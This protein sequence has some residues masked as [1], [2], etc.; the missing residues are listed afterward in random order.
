[1]SDQNN[2]MLIKKYKILT[3]FKIIQI[4]FFIGSFESQQNKAALK[5]PRTLQESTSTI[6]CGEI[7][8]D[9]PPTD[10]SLMSKGS[11]N[12]KIMASDE[13]T[14]SVDMAVHRSGMFN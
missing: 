3:L 5:V 1:M 12:Q 10:M 7:V 9:Y 8:D 6:K 4:T 2:M 13:M 14:N 11:D